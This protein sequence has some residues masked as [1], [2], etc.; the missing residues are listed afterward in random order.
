[1]TN[2]KNI[3]FIIFQTVLSSLSF[4]LLFNHLCISNFP[5]ISF[6]IPIAL[7]VLTIM[8]FAILPDK[9]NFT[10]SKIFK[11][12]ITIYLYLSTA[13]YIIISTY[14]ITDYFFTNMPYLQSSIILILII[15]LFSNFKNKYIYDVSSIIFLILIF[16]NLITIFNTSIFK[17]D[18]LYNISFNENITNYSLLY[19]VSFLYFFLDPIINYF[20]HDDINIKKG[21][22]TSNIISSIVSFITIF[23]NY[24]YFGYQYLEM[25]LFP[26]FSALITFIGPEFLDHFTILILINALC[27]VLLKG[28]YNISYIGNIFKNNVYSNLLS[29]ILLFAVCYF[30]FRYSFGFSQINFLFGLVLSILIF[31]IYF[32]II[33]KKEEKH[34]T[35]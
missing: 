31:F 35:Q 34:E 24:L 21:I 20:I 23:I 11:I 14:I 25:S 18:L 30:T 19:M 26:G 6:L 13:L 2:N 3:Q 5:K 33:I 15:L 9:F 17:T 7:C 8:L 4:F 32:F 10:N 16:I 28:A 12:V 27:W 29:F 22:I 1:M